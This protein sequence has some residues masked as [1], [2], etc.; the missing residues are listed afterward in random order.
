MLSWD[1]RKKNI[2]TKM[3]DYHKNNLLKCVIFYK[4][5]SCSKRINPLIAAHPDKWFVPCVC[6]ENEYDELHMLFS[7]S[8]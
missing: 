3:L 1:T 6:E 5:F 2:N 7:S 4:P 8:R